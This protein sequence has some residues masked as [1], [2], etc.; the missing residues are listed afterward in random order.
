[1]SLSQEQLDRIAIAARV[2]SALSLLGVFAII[3]TFSLS[4]FFRSPIHRIIFYIAFYNLV[5][6]VATMIT[7]SGP[8]AGNTSSLC[9][10]QAFALQMYVARSR[11]RCALL[12]TARLGFR[13]RM[14][15]GL[16]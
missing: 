15:F 3:G 6:T 9:R 16:L 11:T 2:S 12:L 14:Y 7:V 10:F 8:N 13:S 4:R 5:G 1:M